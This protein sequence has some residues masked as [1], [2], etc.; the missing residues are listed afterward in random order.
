MGVHHVYRVQPLLLRIFDTVILYKG[1]PMQ[2]EKSD[3]AVGGQMHSA[4]P[5]PLLH[6]SP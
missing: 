5:Y 1:R 2:L 3:S 4:R 6:L